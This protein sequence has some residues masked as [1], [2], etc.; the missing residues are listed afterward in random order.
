M[1][2]VISSDCN[3]NKGLPNRTTSLGCQE[4]IKST[5]SNKFLEIHWSR[6]LKPNSYCKCSAQQGSSTRE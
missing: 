6:V 3:Q 5:T 2:S 4:H 1:K